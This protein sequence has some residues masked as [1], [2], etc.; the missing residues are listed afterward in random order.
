[1]QD[2]FRPTKLKPPK[3]ISCH[4]IPSKM[5]AEICGVVK[6]GVDVDMRWNAVRLATTLDPSNILGLPTNS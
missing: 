1:M 6:G 2:T 5:E 3:D 4:G